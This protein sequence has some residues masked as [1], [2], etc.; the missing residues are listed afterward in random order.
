MGTLTLG[1]AGSTADL[2]VPLVLGDNTAEWSY[3]RPEH[4]ADFGGV[5]HD[6]APVLYRFTSSLE[7]QSSYEGAAYRLRVALDEPAVL[8]SI[9]L[10]MASVESLGT[11]PDADEH[12]TWA[13]QYCWAVTLVGPATRSRCTAGG[14]RRHQR[15]ARRQRPGR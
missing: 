2:E 12:A 5:Q 4:E 9:G 3:D 13:A 11:R 15:H 1:F 8:T 14:G 6:Q 7:S 10:T